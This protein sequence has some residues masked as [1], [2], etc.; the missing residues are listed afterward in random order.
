[1]P[2]THPLGYALR[3]F[4]MRLGYTQ[5]DLSEASE[6]S[7]SYLSRIENGFA[8]PTSQELLERLAEALKLSETE[9]EKLFASAQDS[10][11]IVHL[12]ADLSLK[13]YE[14]AHHFLRVLAHLRGDSLDRIKQSV[15]EE[16]GEI[17]L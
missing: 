11:K 14:V 2:T 3:K 5:R 16:Q 15:L 8:Q 17:P 12:P 9:K 1:M 10:Q 13:G 7:E 6:V 4:R